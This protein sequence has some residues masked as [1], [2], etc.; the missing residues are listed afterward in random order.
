MKYQTGQMYELDLIRDDIYSG[1]VYVDFPTGTNYYN[2]R[3]W[4][5]KDGVYLGPDEDGVEPVFICNEIE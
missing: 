3:D 4:F 1:R 5:T 2:W